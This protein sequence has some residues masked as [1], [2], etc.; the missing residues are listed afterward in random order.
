MGEENKKD[1]S[2][3]QVDSKMGAEEILEDFFGMNIRS[4]STVKTLALNPRKYF[5]AAQTADWDNRKYTPSLRLWLGLTAIF[6]ALKVF[7][8]RDNSPY[9]QSIVTELS[10]TDDSLD[11]VEVLRNT[12]DLSLI[13]GPFFLVGL[14]FLLALFTNFWS[15][16]LN[17]LTRVRYLFCCVLL[18]SITGIILYILMAAL[19]LDYRWMS[20]IQ[21]VCEFSLVFYVVYAGGMA[22]FKG[23]QRILRTMGM[24]SL[25]YASYIITTTLVFILAMIIIMMPLLA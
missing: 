20:V 18:S 14:F 8:A 13:L 16:K 22:G 12:F 2:S 19:P 1:L 9:L 25:I 4:F 7:W 5:L 10:A 24:T 17:Y 15:E 21:I 23:R 3:S 11:W 6:I